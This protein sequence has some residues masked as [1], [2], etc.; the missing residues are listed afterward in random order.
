M[1]LADIEKIEL[2]IT[3]DCNAACPGCLR[4]QHPEI[5]S[6]GGF[7]LTDF[8]R[9]FPEPWMIEKKLFKFC[10]VLGDPIKNKDC[11]PMVEYVVNHGGSIEISTNAGLCTSDW[12]SRLGEISQQTQRI[13]I[14]FC[15]DG[16]RE[17]NHLYRV[18]TNFDVIERNL[19]AYVE[20]SKRASWIF[21]VFDHNE[22][23]LDTAKKH[24]L[25]LGLQFAERTGMRNSFQ[26][27][28][29]KI[30]ERDKKTREIKVQERTYSTKKHHEKKSQ[31]E[32]LR[33]IVETNDKE[34]VQ[35][36]VNSIECK[37][38]HQNELFISYNQLLWPCCFLWDNYVKDSG[39]TQKKL[40]QHG[41]GWNDLKQH[42]I[43][44]I[45]QHPWF[46]KEL[47]KSWNP[48]HQKH[49]KRCIETCAYKRAYQNEFL[50]YEKDGTKRKKV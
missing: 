45:L 36:V 21:I 27:W 30:K 34:R 35:E 29:A 6:I 42:S 10:G 11:L 9:M 47:A 50:F 43:D 2:E 46:E 41:S 14:N 19:H 40:D 49:L 37:L 16:H 31:Y 32:E 15:I 22:H 20:K 23:E 39:E 28:V 48:E 38:Y 24:A 26:D 44:E 18:N 17:T 3:S 25:G 12:W 8:Q 13:W 4:T 5:Y 7:G 1:K 33:D